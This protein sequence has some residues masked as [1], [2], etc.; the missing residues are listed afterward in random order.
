[1]LGFEEGNLDSHLALKCCNH[2]GQ[3]TNS[4]PFIPKSS[5]MFIEKR[6][7]LTVLITIEN[8]SNSNF[9]YNNNIFISWMTQR[10]KTR[11]YIIDIS[12]Q[13]VFSFCGIE[14]TAVCFQ[15]NWKV[16]REGKNSNKRCG[17]NEVCQKIV[18]Q[19]SRSSKEDQFTMLVP[20]SITL[21]L[22]IL[23]QK[24]NVIFLLCLPSLHLRCPSLAPLPLIQAA[25]ELD[26]QSLC[27]DRTRPGPSGIFFEVS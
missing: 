3:V 21:N 17:K 25:N 16:K 26:Q 20:D 1:M 10:K 8:Y 22:C 18:C 14:D 11:L 15:Y 23:F 24:F 4:Q 27:P 7:V 13:L 9:S 6:S 19:Q 12:L 2:L 5:G